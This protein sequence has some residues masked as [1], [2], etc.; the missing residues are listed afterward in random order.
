MIDGRTVMET[1]PSGRSAQEIAELWK[2]VH[3][4]IS[5]RAAA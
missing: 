5:I 1:T 4:Q 3:A 2:Y